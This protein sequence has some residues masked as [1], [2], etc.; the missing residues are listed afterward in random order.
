MEIYLFKIDKNK[1]IK[2]SL[3]AV[4]SDDTV[5]ALTA[6]RWR[7]QRHEIIQQIYWGRHGFTVHD[8]ID[9]IDIESEVH[10]MKIH[11]WKNKIK[12]TIDAD[13]DF[14]TL[15]KEF[16]GLHGDALQ[17]SPLFYLYVLHKATGYSVYGMG[18]GQVID[19]SVYDSLRMPIVRE[20][21]SIL[22]GKPAMKIWTVGLAAAI[23]GTVMGWGVLGWG[24]F[25]LSVLAESFIGK[26]SPE[27]KIVDREMVVAHA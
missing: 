2:D 8:M 20:S 9:Q 26:I 10:K 11:V 17:T 3:D 6:K 14:A 27:V 23:I 25:I 16:E 13:T 22:W 24:G 15:S 4:I 21:M 5:H 7:W 1:E 12:V 18:A 19:I